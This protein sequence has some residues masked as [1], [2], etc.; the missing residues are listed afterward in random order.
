MKS[1][2]EHFLNTALSEQFAVKYEPI[3]LSGKSYS[4]KVDFSVISKTGEIC[5]LEYSGMNFLKKYLKIIDV[6]KN[7]PNFFVIYDD[8]HLPTQ[9]DIFYRYV[10]AAEYQKLSE[11]T[12][13]TTI[14]RIETFYQN[15]KQLCI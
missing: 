9:L 13:N 14:N 4:L 2:V 1:K 3:I 5:Y 10:N 11:M 6:A 12:V 7:N 15:F 8:Q